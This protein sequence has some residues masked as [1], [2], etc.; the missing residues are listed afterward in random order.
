MEVKIVVEEN[1]REF[2]FF[3]KYV[4]VFEVFLV[5]YL[6]FAKGNVVSGI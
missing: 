4:E 5:Q 1:A 6:K 3:K 2:V